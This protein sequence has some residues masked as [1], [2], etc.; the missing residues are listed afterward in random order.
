MEGR[1]A[2][3]FVTDCEGPLTKNDNAAELAEAFLPQGDRLFAKVSLYDDYLAEVVHKP[4]YKAGDTLRL[5][6]PFFKAFGLDNRSMTKFSRHNIEMIPGA[7]CVLRDVSELIPVY[8][9]STSYSPYI[10]AVCDAMAFPFRNAYCTYVNL[11]DYPLPE[12]EKNVLRDIHATILDLPDFTIP[13]GATSPEDM[14]GEDMK[15]IEKLDTIFWTELPLMDIYRIVEEVSPIGGREK[16]AAIEAIAAVEGAEIHEVMYVG[17][18]ITDVDAFRLVNAGGGMTISFN[19]NDWAVKEAAFAVT[20][21]TA[22]P[23]GWLATLFVNRGKRGFQDLT[24]S[25]ITPENQERISALS[26]R[27]RKEVRTEKIGS[28]G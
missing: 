14:S 1:M 4:G 10:K 15:T 20:S 13:S 26:C 16:A 6:L 21:A 8:I 27:I 2:K 24:M 5:I 28:L 7:D 23:I 12:G 19:G 11:D 18:S 3:V 9:V 17:D 25:Q 22:L